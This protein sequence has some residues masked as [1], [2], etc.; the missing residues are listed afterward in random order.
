MLSLEQQLSEAHADNAHLRTELSLAQEQIAWLKR[1]LFGRSSEQSPAPH[2]DQGRLF[3]EAEVLAATAAAE[4]VAIPAHTR[5]KRGR[6]RLAAELPRIDV[7]HDLP[8]SE[9]V[10]AKDGTALVQI[11]EETSEQLDYQPAKLRV[12]KHIRP[13]Y[14]CPCCA[15]GAVKTAPVPVQLLP[16]SLATPSLLAQIVTAKYVDGL[17]LH[18]QE[19]QFARLGVGLGRATMANWLIKLGTEHVVPLINLM[20]EQLLTAPLVHCDETSLQVLKSD[21]A[22]TADHWIWVRAA[23]PPGRRLVLFDYDPSR[24]GAVPL[25]LLQGFKGLLLTD[26]YEPY[27]AVAATLGIVHAGC[28]AHARRYFDEARRAQ[29]KPDGSDRARVALELIGRLYQIERSIKDATAE[30]RL[31]VRA[32]HSAPIVAQLRAWLEAMAPAVLPQSLLGKAIRYTLGQWP[33]LVRFL[34]HAELPLDNNRLENAI[35][36][37][38][39]GRKGW[40]FADTQAGA[41]ASANLYSLVETA[42][43]NGLEPHAYLT[44]LFTALPHASRVEHFEALLPWNPTKAAPAASPAT[45]MLQ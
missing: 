39:I 44:Q 37:F 31:K 16:K 21:K 45:H 35:R 34:E 41:R 4:S 17:P 12:L 28:W 18:R 23:G 14:A 36:P 24:G 40:L 15:T 13:K 32:E 1:R 25:R 33:K 19:A 2:P 43:A 8:E 42:K 30:V 38:V 27:N 26:G 7:L 3:N 20:N 11:G 29:P 6:K 5:T 10:C 22:P 9:K